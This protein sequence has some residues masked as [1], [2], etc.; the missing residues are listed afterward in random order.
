MKRILTYGVL[1]GILVLAGCRGTESTKPPIHIN[2]NMDRQEKF[3]GQQENVF[4]ENRM[5]MRPP[6]PGTVARGFLRDDSRFYFGRE[7]NGQLVATVP[8]PMTADLLSRGQ[9]RYGI[10]CSVCHGLAGD[11]KGI[12]MVG[13]GGAGYGYVPAP[14]FHVDRLRTIEDGH[15]YDVI[16]NGIRNMPAYAQQIPVADRW[17]IVAYVRALQR[18]QHAPATDVPQSELSRL[19]AGGD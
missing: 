10:Y 8:V 14:D 3:I 16:T 18:S 2:P 9:E 7:A 15:I 13:N 11:G 6:V 12:I 1:A 4:F 17:A 19:Q 5:A